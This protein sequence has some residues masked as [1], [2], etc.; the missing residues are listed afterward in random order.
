VKK[1]SVRNSPA[2]TKVPARHKEE[3]RCSRCWNGD[4]PAAH[5]EDHA[6]GDVHTAA[7]RITESQNGRGWKGPLWVI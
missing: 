7:H 2:D 3:R 5:G 4:S 6:G 1:K